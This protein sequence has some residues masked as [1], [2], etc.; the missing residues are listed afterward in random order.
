MTF[1]SQS[2]ET[3]KVNRSKYGQNCL[4]VSEVDTTTTNYPPK[5]VST[6][7][8]TMIEHTNYPQQ[9]SIPETFY[10]KFQQSSSIRTNDDVRL[11]ETRMY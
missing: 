3:S 2:G 5:A 7:N 4:A 9:E 8:T 6:A 10:N 11:M 1:V